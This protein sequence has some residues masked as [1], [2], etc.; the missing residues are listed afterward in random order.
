MAINETV[1]LVSHEDEKNAT[2]QARILSAMDDKTL[3]IICVNVTPETLPEGLAEPAWWEG[4][5]N[6]WALVA[7]A[8]IALE[9]AA[10]HETDALVFEQDVIFVDD[11]YSRFSA[12]LENTPD[13]W[14]Q[15]YLGGQLLA[16]A[17]HPPQ[18]VN[19]YVQHAPT[20]HRTH[21]WLTRSTAC[22]RV[23]AWL[24]ESMWA[25]RQTLDWRLM[26]LHLKPDFKAYM[27]A[28]RWLCGQAGGVSSLDGK[29]YP[30]RWWEF[31]EPYASLEHES[32]S[33][34]MRQQEV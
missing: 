23:A 13:D 18:P 12:L 26:Y 3:D 14:S 24:R 16:R 19:A 21:A 27:P 31:N 7:A 11:F 10:L 2:A 22:R 34:F 1:Y 30:D 4:H 9:H 32:Y 29:V 17:H 5:A 33:A 6:R 20:V 28:D 15:I 25:G 8:I